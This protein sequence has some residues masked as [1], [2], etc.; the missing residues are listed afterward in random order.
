MMVD[1]MERIDDA[2]EKDF[3]R[4]VASEIA[5][6]KSEDK[7]ITLMDPETGRVY[8]ELPNGERVYVK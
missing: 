4:Y 2:F 1:K 3:Q 6:K 7:P 5:R 8:R